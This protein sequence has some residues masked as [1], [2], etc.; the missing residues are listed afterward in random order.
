MLTFD[1]CDD[2][3]SWADNVTSL[4]RIYPAMFMHDAAAVIAIDLSVNVG[5]PVI[6]HHFT[7][8]RYWIAISVINPRVSVLGVIAVL[9]P[10]GGFY[11]DR[12][13]FESHSFLSLIV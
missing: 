4:K 5:N 6:A 11:D 9:K 10:L 1:T 2:P 12:F 8:N 13:L 3:I 7:F